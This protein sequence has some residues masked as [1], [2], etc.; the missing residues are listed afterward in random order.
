MKRAPFEEH[1][2][3]QH[4]QQHRLQASSS[5]SSRAQ[6]G[7]MHGGSAKRPKHTVEESPA[8]S[9]A[10]RAAAA[11]SNRAC[12]TASESAAASSSS[13][14]AASSSSAS[15]S[16]LANSGRG[17]RVIASFSSRPSSS[18]SGR[19]H[20]PAKQL[21]LTQLKKV[22]DLESV[23]AM[24]AG[25]EKAIAREEW[26]RVKTMLHTLE[27]V[28]V[29][30][31]VLE[32]TGLGKVVAPL[33]KLNGPSPPA[34][35]LPPL[36]SVEAIA[37]ASSSSSGAPSS[38]PEGVEDCESSMPPLE[39][40]FADE[41]P[42]PDAADEETKVFEPMAIDL[43]SPSDENKENLHPAASDVRSQIVVLAY[44]LVAIWKEQVKKELSEEQLKVASSS[45]ASLVFADYSTHKARIDTYRTLYYRLTTSDARE[46]TAQKTARKQAC[47]VL[48][49]KDLSCARLAADLEGTLW[50][51]HQTE[52]RRRQA[53][54]TRKHGAELLSSEKAGAEEAQLATLTQVPPAYTF[55]ARAL[56]ALVAVPK[57]LQTL[58]QWI[59]TYSLD[60]SPQAEEVLAQRKD[61]LAKLVTASDASARHS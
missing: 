3:R 1:R 16:P 27:D 24:T 44:R 46:T 35:P 60:A 61:V 17:H 38:S 58:R 12:S 21:T 20:P 25:L 6:Q 14:A 54:R 56:L 31:A 22:T 57:T 55:H 23:R 30:K 53:E 33:K 29:T 9:D 59:P 15:P 10:R 26:Q 18:S 8:A 34:A 37:A 49:P 13:H 52:A 4:Q 41:Q 28:F 51:H 11:A 48:A 40:P 32:Q 36:E 43:T 45:N 2:Q 39:H 5:S 50:K 42:M 47:G 7:T 19:F